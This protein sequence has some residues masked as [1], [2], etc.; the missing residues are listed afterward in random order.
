[1]PEASASTNASG[2]AE[3]VEQLDGANAASAWPKGWLDAERLAQADAEPHNW[4]TSGR[5]QEGTYYSPLDQINHETVERLGVAWEYDLGTERGI[6]ATPIVIDGVMVFSGVWGRVYVLDAE[7]GAELWT[8]D[9]EVT[10]YDPQ[11]A[12]RACCDAVSR[13]LSV[14]GGKVYASALDGRL[15]ALDLKTGETLWSVQTIPE[16]EGMAYT[17]SGAPQIAGDVIVVGSSGADFPARGYVAGFDLETG[18]LRWRSYLTPS[19]PSEG[20]QE[21]EAL[22]KALPTWSEET[23]WSFGGGGTVWDGMAFDAELGLLYV[24]VGNA[25]PYNRWR[26]SPGGGDNLYLA[27]IV[28]MNPKDGSVV[29]AFQ[30]TPGDHWDYTATSKFILADLPLNGSERKVIMQAPKNGFFY[31]LDR[32]TGEYLSAEP[33]VFANWTKGLDPE[34]GRPI[35]NADVADYDAEPRLVFPGMQGGHNWHPMAHNLKTGLVYI[36]AIEAG[37]VFV[38][39]AQRP[40]GTIDGMFQA[41]GLFVEDYDP[42]ALRSLM[43]ELPALS[44]LTK[45][46]GL[47]ETPSSHSVL[48]AWDP[49]TQ[50][51]VWEHKY[52]DTFWDGGVMTSGGGLV[53]RGDALGDLSVFAAD[54]GALLKTIPLHSSIMAAPMSYAVGDTQYVSVISGYGGGGGLAFPPNSA[55]YLY[56]NDNRVITLKLDGAEPAARPLQEDPPAPDLPDTGAALETLA[57]GEILFTKHCMRCHM[58]ERGVMPNLT[59]SWALASAEGFNAIVREG[60]LSLNGMARF[61]DVLGDAEAEAIRSYLISQTLD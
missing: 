53:F 16:N 6:E 33:Y 61:D 21:T 20:P 22:T 24:G 13:G 27:S 23:D 45:T 46:A 50:K 58:G 47:K 32:Q 19:D 60:A 9:P 55:A 38:N 40:V 51:T 29:W 42:E 18:E 7:T 1:M 10:A 52:P 26:R 39:T 3:P 54:T 4:F 2:S 12:R 35:P 5:D 57:Q 49:V 37:M 30:T 43:G 28:A 44:A 36:P 41:A 31:V 8:F 11:A 59:K 17:V 34:S 25:A 56:G 15:F 48:R 14:W